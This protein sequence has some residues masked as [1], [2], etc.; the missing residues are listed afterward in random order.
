LQAVEPF[1]LDERHI[2][3]NVN[4]FQRMRTDPNSGKI[5]AGLSESTK[6]DYIEFYAEIDLLVAVTVCPNGDNTRYY[7]VPGRDVVRPLRIEVYET[8][9]PPRAF[10]VWTDWRPSWRGKWMPSDAGTSA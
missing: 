8:G 1:G 3:D 4:L 5:L 9:V 7:S 10:P 6:G 2:R